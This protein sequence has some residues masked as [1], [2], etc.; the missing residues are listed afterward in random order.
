MERPNKIRRRS[1]TGQ[2]DVHSYP[3]PADDSDSA[4][5][6]APCAAD[7]MVVVD[8]GPTNGSQLPSSVVQDG[9][10][11]EASKAVAVTITDDGDNDSLFGSPQRA[12]TRKQ[13]TQGRVKYGKVYRRNRRPIV[14]TSDDDDDDDNDDDDDGS[15]FGDPSSSDEMDGRPSKKEADLTGVD[16]PEA[17]SCVLMPHQRIGLEWL[18]RHEHGDDKGGVLADDMGLGKTIQALALIHANPPK[19]SSRKTTLIVAPLALLQQW[20]R[21]IDEKTKPG[22]KLKVHVFHGKGRE[23]S[24]RQLLSY[25]VVLT[26]YDSITVEFKMTE[27]QKEGM[28]LLD[29]GVHFHRVIL[30]EGHNIKN[31][32]T[33]VARGAFRLQADY[34]LVMTGT[35]L[36]NRAEELY[37]IA[38]F[39]N[40]A[41]YDDWDYFNKNIAKPL[42][43]LDLGRRVRAAQAMEKV[44]HLT[45]KTMLVRKKT[46]LLDGKPIISLPERTDVVEYCTFDNDELIFYIKLQ[47]EVEAQLRNFIGASKGNK[48]FSHLLVA[49]LRLRQVCCHP[50]MLE[51]YRKQK[52]DER[53]QYL[54]DLDAETAA[55]VKASQDAADGPDRS[56][57][58]LMSFSCTTNEETQRHIGTKS[59]KSKHYHELEEHY[60]PSAKITKTLE[61]LASIREKDPQDK[62]IIF[63]FFTSYLEIL[64]IGIRRAGFNFKRYNGEMT[65]AHKDMVVRDFTN[66][67]SSTK[68]LLTSLASVCRPLPTITYL[69]LYIL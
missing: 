9:D 17:M 33:L 19:D 12:T 38:R 7:E 52:D 67:E 4:M 20:P 15:L 34:R 62:I 50:N 55:A 64:A 27:I 2:T 54:E 39:L 18:L 28:V 30:D 26:N 49:L 42:K 57:S 51:T 40:I 11:N 21:E 13:Q 31:R 14:I 45:T 48:D 56:P 29:P 44:N 16:T 10:F 58:E 22:H 36:M 68:I 37:S 43:D 1:L 65:A 53:A 3:S 66:P 41:P 32:K 35:P 8:D 59:K 24:V 23:I 46:D 6:N 63:S 61:I 47:D 25:D 69:P 60:Q 5:A